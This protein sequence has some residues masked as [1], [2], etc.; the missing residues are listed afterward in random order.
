M[1]EHATRAVVSVNDL[2]DRVVSE[3]ELCKQAAI[4]MMSHAVLCGE[5]LIEL[6]SMVEKDYGWYA[7]CGEHLPIT[8]AMAGHYM[9]I[10]KHS[11]L[12]LDSGVTTITA[13]RRLLTDTLAEAPPKYDKETID[14]A[15]EMHGS[16]VS[17]IKISEILGP[18]KS[19]IRD[20][21]DPKWR[22]VRSEY[23]RARSAKVRRAL[24]S[25]ERQDAVRKVGRG[26]DVAYTHV[27]KALESLD[28]YRGELVDCNKRSARRALGSLESAQDCMAL[29]ATAT[30]NKKS[31]E[32]VG[33]AMSRL[34][35]AE[36]SIVAD[37]KRGNLTPATIPPQN[38]L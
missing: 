17:I 5:A 22:I 28:G 2:R 25:Q 18:S 37:A 13:A 3:Y 32:A 11:E 16:G 27:R 36:D 29:A 34:Y 23:N 14:R 30:S 8:T 31:L 33:S 9:R 4:S 38:R 7:W 6:R 15:I 26:L 24:R 35:E 19:T 1:S 10:A 12:I 20:W 21:I